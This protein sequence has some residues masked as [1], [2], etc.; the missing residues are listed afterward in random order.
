MEAT[1]GFFGSIQG[2]FA[3][4]DELFIKIQ[5]NCKDVIEYI[6]KIGIHYI[7]NFDLDLYGNFQ[8]KIFIRINGIDFQLGKT[9]MLELEDVQV[10]SIYFL[11]DVDDLFY[12]DYQY[13]KG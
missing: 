6:S 3:A 5:E 2:P 7:G 8:K 12:I 11:E 1:N 10:T 4:N 13:K 9:R